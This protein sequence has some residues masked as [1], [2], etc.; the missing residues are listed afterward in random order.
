MAKTTTSNL[1]LEGRVFFP[2]SMLSIVRAALTKSWWGFGLVFLTLPLVIRLLTSNGQEL[3]VAALIFIYS[4]LGHIAFCLFG[5]NMTDMAVKMGQQLTPEYPTNFIWAGVFLLAMYLLVTMV[6][7]SRF[8]MLMLVSAIATALFTASIGL[9][10]TNGIIGLRLLLTTSALIGVLLIIDYLFDN[11]SNDAFL[12][13]YGQVYFWVNFLLI[14]LSGIALYRW[15][16]YFN[17][18]APGQTRAV[19]WLNVVRSF[20]DVRNPKQVKGVK[21]GYL[22]AP[23]FLEMGSLARRPLWW[24][25]RFGVIDPG[26]LRAHLFWYCMLPV[27]VSF[28]GEISL[29]FLQLLAIVMMVIFAPGLLDTGRTAMRR[30][31]LQSPGL[32]RQQFLKELSKFYCV[33]GLFLMLAGL[34]LMLIGKLFGNNDLTMESLALGV[35]GFAANTLCLLR[36]EIAN[37]KVR[38]WQ[39]GVLTSLICAVG[40]LL[41]LYL[42]FDVIQISQWLLAAVALVAYLSMWEMFG[43]WSR[44]DIEI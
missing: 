34:L 20:I 1:H 36:A 23:G 21:T 5:S 33:A 37:F 27:L 41:N 7:F 24:W 38:N 19:H 16:L 31:Y 18:Q 12:Y 6:L 15:Q 26:T 14:L 42:R 32:S 3:Q 4:G 28:G 17:R 9:F 43:L 10:I 25:F 44:S 11:I 13:V 35:I 22:L 29:T 39:R 8:D 2:R 30:L 40:I